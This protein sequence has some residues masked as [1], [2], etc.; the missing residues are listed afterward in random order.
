MSSVKKKVE[1]EINE[2]CPI[3]KMDK[4][5]NPS[6]I[7]LV[8]PC[9]HKMCE[10]C[11]NRIF[12]GGS[13]P[14]PICQTS[15]K[16]S[17]F[18]KPIFEDMYVEKECRIRK[19][20]WRIFQKSEDDFNGDLRAYNDYLEKIEDMI[21]EMVNDPDVQAVNVKID[22]LQKQNQDA[23][24]QNTQAEEEEDELL[25]LAVQQ[26]EREIELRR[27]ADAQN[28]VK[29][30]Q[31]KLQQKSLMHKD[32]QVED[33]DVNLQSVDVI[34]NV[35]GQ[36]LTIEERIKLIK[37]QRLAGS[38]QSRFMVD[39]LQSDYERTAEIDLDGVR[40]PAIE[41]FTNAGKLAGGFDISAVYRKS[42][43]SA[44]IAIDVDPI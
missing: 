9:Y 28:M 25:R 44:L 36:S 8:S 14:C 37:Q 5:L 18:M 42:L 21:F 35:P 38:A 13:A 11:V 4:F 16:K 41:A 1:G 17:N 27:V 26:Q 3:C 33:G 10:S 43:E 34:T 12:A 31:L 19:R 29:Q 30:M 6:M 20:V 15:L 7:L 23:L 39:P 2:P 22:Q 40:D 24:F 32:R